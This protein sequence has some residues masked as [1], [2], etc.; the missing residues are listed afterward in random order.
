MIQGA[1]A[2][3]TQATGVRFAMT[4]IAAT[5]LAVVAAIAMAGGA[6]AAEPLQVTVGTGDGQIQAQAYLPGAF[7]VVVG[8]SVTFTVGSDEPHSV[9]FGTGPDGVAPDVWPV[10][11]WAPPPP[12]PPPTPAE[13]GEAQVDGTSFVHTGLLWRGSTATAVFTSPGTYVFT[14]VIHPGMYG[15]VD[16]LEAGSTVTT[17]AEADAAGAA[18]AEALLSQTDAVRAARLA[19]VTIIDNADGTKTFNIFADASTVPV[20]MPGGGGG[21]LEV[22]EMLPTGLK[23]GIGDTV[24]WAANGAHTVTFPATGQ[25]PTTIDPF[26]PAEGGDVHAPGTFL[27]S[28]LLNAGPGAPSSYTLTFPAA[29]TFP[30]ICALHVFLGQQGVIAVGQPLPSAAAEPVG[31]EAPASPES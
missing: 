4:G 30:Y 1:I 23:I 12:A 22:Y 11:G 21:Y 7:S 2:R 3:V 25:D 20:D 14:C 24:H 27:T 26:G 6:S 8:D 19:D 29:G 9:T 31:S 28:G 5:S 18:T 13:L 10:T 15:E 17:Q 16:V